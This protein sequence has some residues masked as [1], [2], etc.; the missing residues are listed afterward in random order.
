[1]P[2]S[3]RDRP[4]RKRIVRSPS[5]RLS[6]SWSRPNSMSISMPSHQRKKR[7]NPITVTIKSI[8]QKI[9]YWK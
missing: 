5:G 9:K 2:N 3:V 7:L 6:T 1:M 4:S 8:S